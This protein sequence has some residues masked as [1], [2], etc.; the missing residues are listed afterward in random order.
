MKE[1]VRKLEN[2]VR[3]KENAKIPVRKCENA[4]IPAGKDEKEAEKK[5]KNQR[6][7]KPRIHS[8][9]H[10]EQEERAYLQVG[11]RRLSGSHPSPAPSISDLPNLEGC[12]GLRSSA[13][14]W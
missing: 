13:W 9:I 6:S 4:K 10:S 12:G 11:G 2:L 8:G 14:S 3:K 5:K 7:P 1:S